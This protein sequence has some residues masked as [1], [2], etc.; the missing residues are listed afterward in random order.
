[1]VE[2]VLKPRSTGITGSEIIFEENFNW[3][4]FGGPDDQIG[5][6]FATR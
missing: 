6:R 3:L 5:L 4:D 1:V 2:A